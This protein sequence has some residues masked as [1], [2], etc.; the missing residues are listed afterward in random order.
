[1]L[2][3]IVAFIF[4]LGNAGFTTVIDSCIMQTCPCI[5]CASERGERICN[6]S[7]TPSQG[8]VLKDGQT[9]HVELVAGGLLALQALHEKDHGDRPSK[10][11]FA[12]FQGTIS[13]PA[14]PPFSGKPHYKTFF[15]DATPLSG[16]KYVLY[17]TF[18]I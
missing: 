9:C 11:V 14:G 10:V 3:G 17:S 15:H 8:V 13:S 1:M 16:E 4:F 2:P 18:L 6:P 12:S 5:Q 7:D